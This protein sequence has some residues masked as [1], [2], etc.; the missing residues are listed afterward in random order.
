M[1]NEKIKI[2]LENMHFKEHQD[3]TENGLVA[4]SISATLPTF[5]F[6]TKCVY[7]LGIIH[8]RTPDCHPVSW[9]WMTSQLNIAL[10]HKWQ[11]SLV[12]LAC[13]DM[14]SMSVCT[15]R[16][17]QTSGRLL[18]QELNVF[19]VGYE[20]KDSFYLL[21]ASLMDMFWGLNNM[22]CNIKNVLQLNE[23]N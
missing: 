7:S 10:I 18:V 16:Q 15:T 23:T 17:W 6:C 5:K 22:L 4:H 19:T 1:K 9:A 14:F 12:G 3:L 8:N 11:G 2:N 20:K 21:L 13:F